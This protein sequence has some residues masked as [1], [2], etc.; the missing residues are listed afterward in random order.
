MSYQSGDI[1]D[2]CIYL[3][4][5][6]VVYCI[7]GLSVLQLLIFFVSLPALYFGEANIS[8]C[9][10][11]SDRQW[12]DRTVTL[13]LWV[14]WKL[15][16]YPINFCLKCGTVFCIQILLTNSVLYL[17]VLCLC[18]YF[19]TICRNTVKQVGYRSA[20]SAG[21]LNLLPFTFSG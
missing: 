20:S 3:G 9:F 2:Y 6:E 16:N 10:C 19:S 11:A 7:C 17:H 8:S 18:M 12:K 1:C 5:T 21:P 14:T 13:I 15:L 4:G